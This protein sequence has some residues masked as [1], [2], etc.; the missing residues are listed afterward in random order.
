MQG[1]QPDESFTPA[2]E[3][4][5]GR[6]NVIVVQHAI[7]GQPIQRWYKKWK[8]PNGIAPES[9]GDLYDQLMEKVRSETVG[10]EIATV[11]FFWM[12]GERDAKMGWGPVYEAGRKWSF[13]GGEGN[14]YPNR[15]AKE[16][17]L[18]TVM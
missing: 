5:F 9:T 10:Q 4:A 1:H 7:G 16:S 3:A 12:Q 11:S 14:F 17:E 2:M 15:I 6:E 18:A 8:D 13:F